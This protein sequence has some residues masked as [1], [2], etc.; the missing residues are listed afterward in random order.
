VDGDASSETIDSLSR[1]LNY[2]FPGADSSV[3]R[4]TFGPDRASARGVRDR[5]Y[6]SRYFVYGIPAGDISDKAIL[7]DLRSLAAGTE[8][9]D[10]TTLGPA[11]ANPNT[12]HF[13]ARKAWTLIAQVDGFTSSTAIAAVIAIRKV[14]EPDD[15]LPWSL[16][17]DSILL[18]PL[19]KIAIDATDDEEGSVQHVVDELETAVGLHSLLRVSGPT[20]VRTDDPLSARSAAEILGRKAF[21]ACVADFEND[22]SP[23]GALAYLR[24]LGQ[25]RLQQLGKHVRERIAIGGLTVEDAATRFVGIAVS[26]SGEREISQLYLDDFEQLVPEE[27]WI[28]AVE[29]SSTPS[30]T[31]LSDTSFEGRRKYAI[32]ELM[33]RKAERATQPDS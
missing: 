12:T 3:R 16:R 26:S 14:V 1:M 5:E 2:L 11:L 18:Q 22:D 7:A 8:L 31:N 13:A 23:L 32:R 30:D 4:M 27:V 20:A 19:A 28:A 25:S 24:Y 17:G 6:F 33:S 21:D 9:S 15:Y 10:T 29:T